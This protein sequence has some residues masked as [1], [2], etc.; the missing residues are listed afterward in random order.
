MKI[1]RVEENSGKMVNVHLAKHKG[2][3]GTFVYLVDSKEGLLHTKP[4]CLIYSRYF[5]GFFN[6]LQEKLREDRRLTNVVPQL[7]NSEE[8]NHIL[9]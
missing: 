5:P 7:R 8:G 3:V 2:K 6:W 9:S 1:P 4:L